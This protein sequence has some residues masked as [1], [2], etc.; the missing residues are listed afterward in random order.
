MHPDRAL[1]PESAADKWADDAD[2][3]ELESQRLGQNVLHAFHELG[4]VVEREFLISL[5]A[6]NRS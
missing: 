2:V 1:A 3:F 6:R 4:R 5:P